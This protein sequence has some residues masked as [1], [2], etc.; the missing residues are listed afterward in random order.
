MANSEDI[1]SVRISVAGD[2]S[3]LESDFQQAFQKAQD[4]GATLASVI[5]D[6]VKAPDVGPLNDALSSIGEGATGQLDVLQAGLASVSIGAQEAAASIGA[7]GEQASSAAGGV[8]TFE[9]RI[10]A[11]VDQGMTLSEAL[12]A[13]TEAM[14]AIGGTGAEAASALE[15]AGS[16]AAMAAEQLTLFDEAAQVPCADA[17]GQLNLFASELEVTAADS[18]AAASG[19]GALGA[20]FADVPAEIAPAAESLKQFSEGAAAVVAQQQAAD[21]ALSQAQG[22]FAELSAAYE[23]GSVSANTLA[24]AAGDLSSAFNSAN[25]AIQE[26]GQSVDVASAAFSGLNS[27][28]GLVGISLTLAGFEK[29]AESLGEITDGVTR[30][31]TALTAL[32]GDAGQ[33]EA[34]L[35]RLS[36]LGVQDGL[37]MPALQSAVTRMETIL[38]VGTDLVG[39]LGQLADSTGVTGKSIEA[40]ADSFDRIIESGKAT[41]KS[42]LSLGLNMDDLK[43]AMEDAGVSAGKL[44]DG[45]T[46]AFAALDKHDQ[47]IVLQTALEKFKGIAEDIANN[48]FSG[49][50]HSAMAQWDKDI[51]IAQKDLGSLVGDTLGS[52]LR[53]AVNFAAGLFVSFGTGVVV[54]ID[55]VKGSLKQLQIDFMALGQ[56]AAAAATGNFTAAALAI[57]AGFAAAEKASKESSDKINADLDAG[58][59]IIQD[60]MGQTAKSVKPVIESLDNLGTAGKSAADNIAKAFAQ[61]ATFENQ[62]GSGAGVKQLQADFEN[63][64]KAINMVAKVDLPAAIKA[65]DDYTAAQ[66]R[67]GAGMSVIM[68]AFTEES[69]LINQLAKT[70]LPGASA[71]MQTVLDRFIAAKEPIGLV[72]AAFDAQEKIIN[73]LAKTDLPAAAAAQEKVTAALIAGNEPMGLLNQSFAA[74]EKIYL[75]MAKDGLP[76]AADGLS[77]LAEQEKAA[78]EPAKIVTD[79][80][81]AEQKVLQDLGKTDAPAA[82]AGLSKLTEEEVKLQQPIQVVTDTFSAQQ[83]I[84]QDYAKVDLPAAITMMG[85]LAQ[86]EISLGAPIAVVTSAFQAQQKLLEDLGK[87]DLPGAIKGLEDLAAAEVAA[88]EPMQVVTG[89]LQAAEKE[90]NLLAKTDLPA[91]IVAM[92]QLVDKEVA[93]NQPAQIITQ[94]LQAQEALIKQLAATDLPGAIVAMGQLA[95]KEIDLGQPAGVVTATLKDQQALINSLATHD[96]PAA[97]AAQLAFINQMIAMKQ[98]SQDVNAAI[99]QEIKMIGALATTNLPAAIAALAQFTQA[100]VTLGQS[101]QAT[102]SQLQVQSNW[103]KN[104]AQ[105]DLP[106][107]IAA[108]QKFIDQLQHDVPGAYDAIKKA[109]LD[110]LNMEIA[111]AERTGTDANGQVLA[112]EKVTLAHQAAQ[113]A[114]HGYADEVIKGIN[115]I[116]KGFDGLGSAMADAIVNGKNLGDALVNEFKKIGQSVLAD[117]INLALV[118]L[119]KDLVDLIESILPKHV[120]AVAASTAGTTAL[121]TASTAT[122]AAQTV[123]AAASV[124]AT[125]AVTALGIASSLAAIATYTLVGAIAAVIGAIAGIAGDVILSHISSDTGHIEVNTRASLAELMNIRQD[126]WD[127]HNAL[128]SKLDAIQGV[129][130]AVYDTLANK[131]PDATGI[132]SGPADDISN[133]ATN[134]ASILTAIGQGNSYLATLITADGKIGVDADAIAQN[135]S[136]ISAKMDSLMG[137]VDAVTSAILNVLVPAIVHN[138]ATLGTHA[139]ILSQ[140]YTAQMGTMSAVKDFQGQYH[141][142][143]SLSLAEQIDAA[144]RALD[145]ALQQARAAQNT[146]DEVAA[147]KQAQSVDAELSRLATL[148]G[149]TALAAQYASSAQALETQIDQLSQ[150]VDA[151]GQQVYGGVVDTGTQVAYAATNAGVTVSNA[152]VNS[153]SFIASSVVG[154]IGSVSSAL[155]GFTASMSAWAASVKG[156][157]G[158]ATSETGATVSAPVSTSTSGSVP[159]TGP[160]SSTYTPPPSGAGSSGTGSVGFTGGLPLKGFKGYSSSDTAPIPS[161][162]LGGFNTDDGL[163]MLHAGEWVVPPAPATIDLPADVAARIRTEG[164]VG[165]MLNAMA[166]PPPPA[167]L[168][169]A[170]GNFTTSNITQV[171]T[172][173][174]YGGNAREV[175]QTISDYMKRVSPKMAVA[176]A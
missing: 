42:L 66:I 159:V 20:A 32:T 36:D 153:A 136:D 95:Q 121:G 14:S 57:S 99:D 65:V 61:I 94:T 98:P 156:S 35:E 110:A 25:P 114:A 126:D 21:A 22:V 8:A 166:A 160:G 33:A 131:T 125:A 4:Q 134:I 72:T 44:A 89:T 77:K 50:F 120:A 91:A 144:R 59:K 112:I 73:Q 145:V 62:I 68:Q 138:G 88:N 129:M 34:I 169:P 47:I 130:Q 90:I 161:Y 60:I 172:F 45:V 151:S 92:G 170:P 41:A 48:T 30:A 107:A 139:A 116:L 10:Q 74:Q 29:F 18:Q 85:D 103:I 16:A 78:G 80:L 13:D 152:V 40:A 9:E 127:Q 104:L 162:D 128:I 84:I 165:N 81:I 83:K 56:A 176:S 135:T 3:S 171:N 157:G 76:G 132:G 86:H 164:D 2:F 64:S 1:G 54:A 143:A 133:M 105:T 11:L 17:A 111:Y 140:M 63:A 173:N 109:Q 113:L 115:D 53:E 101:A 79:T 154:A 137:R 106:A 167:D 149:N 124:T 31:T 142:D 147:L 38:P 102:F 69:K 148:Q 174:V 37:S 19:V 123:Q 175:V 58:A 67:N 158:V 75:E 96:L 150:T 26:T 97:T 5:Q 55:A 168:P 122:A 49:V 6:A 141:S 52:Q 163:A 146:A 7:M 93:L 108:Q 71:A 27:V 155:A 51:E 117:V 100:Q 46:K 39:I 87:A 43:G 15:Q 82:I 12:T 24:R 118:P 23:A 70:D 119:K 28:L